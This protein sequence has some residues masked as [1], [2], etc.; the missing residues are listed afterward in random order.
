MNDHGSSHAAAEYAAALPAMDEHA[1]HAP[2]Q[3]GDTVAAPDCCNDQENCSMTSCYTA[4]VMLHSD[5]STDDLKATSA[6]CVAR[7]SNV[8]HAHTTLFK[9]PI[10]L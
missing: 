10:S 6:H 4:A 8:L 9:P 1:H 7:V 2:A 3:A 5:F